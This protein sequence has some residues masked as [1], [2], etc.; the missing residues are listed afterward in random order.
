MKSLSVRPC[1]TTLRQK[2]AH[3]EAS[4]QAVGMVKDC[5]VWS[6]Q[7][8]PT[9]A[10][11]AKADASNHPLKRILTGPICRWPNSTPSF[12]RAFMRQMR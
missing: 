12:Y 7:S 11:K 2:E 8:G 4:E 5:A 1:S 9:T 3:C 10:A 6:A